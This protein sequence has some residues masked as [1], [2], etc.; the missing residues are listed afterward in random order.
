MLATVAVAV[1][2][3]PHVVLDENYRIVEVSPAAQAGFGP[4]L[5]Q[6][7]MASFPDS[8]PL[9][10][11]YYDHARQTGEVVEFVQY[12]DG[13]VVQ[14]KVVPDGGRLTVFWETLCIL[15]VLTLDGLQASLHTVLRTLAAAEEAL[16]RDHVRRSLRIIG[17]DG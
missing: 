9:F 5:G 8:R 4:L 11:P 3:A 6:D 17:G 2:E 7:V 16:H 15:D 12:Y 10:R 13:Y 14:L 1:T